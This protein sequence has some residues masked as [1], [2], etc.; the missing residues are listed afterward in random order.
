M[1]KPYACQ[2]WHVK[3][4]DGRAVAVIASAALLHARAAQQS[5]ASGE[6]RGAHLAPRRMPPSTGRC[7]RKGGQPA[8]AYLCVSYLVSVTSVQVEVDKQAPCRLAAR[9]AALVSAAASKSNSKATLIPRQHVLL[10]PPAALL[11][12]Q[13]AH[14]AAGRTN[15]GATHPAAARPAPARRGSR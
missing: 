12:V 6:G 14:A 8:G 13:E 4:A 15:T 2:G 1:C 10:Q 5:V 9:A 3:F 7:A 11:K